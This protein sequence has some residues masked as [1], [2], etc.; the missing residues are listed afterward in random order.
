MDHVAARLEDMQA[1]HGCDICEQCGV[2]GWVD[3]LVLGASE[4]GDGYGPCDSEDI[5]ELSEDD[6]RG[7]SRVTRRPASLQMASSSTASSSPVSS[8]S[9]SASSSTS[10]Y[11]RASASLSPPPPGPHPR[12]LHSFLM[13]KEEPDFEARILIRGNKHGIL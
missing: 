11:I 12:P 1:A 8:P 2:F 4:D 5:D 9:L 3:N 6:F 10:P 13:H 7:S